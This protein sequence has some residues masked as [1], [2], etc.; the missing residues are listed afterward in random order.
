M[1]KVEEFCCGVDERE[2]EG[3][4]GVGAARDYAVKEEFDIRRSLT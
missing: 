3:D 2:T 1:G 4:E